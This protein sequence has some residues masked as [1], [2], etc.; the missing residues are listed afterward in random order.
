MGV[1]VVHHQGDSLGC[2][3]LLCDVVDEVR[4]IDLG[5]ALGHFGHAWAR[6]WL[7]GHEDITDSKPLVNDLLV[8]AMAS[9]PVERH[10]TSV[11]DK[12]SL[13]PI[14]LSRA[15]MQHLGHLFAAAPF[16]FQ[17]DF[18]CSHPTFCH[19]YGSYRQI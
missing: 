9:L 5:L 12:A 11:F 7:V 13:D 10:T 4:P 6:Q 3:V 2:W 1:G 14:D 16:Y 19:L 17:G 18:E 15:H 8:A